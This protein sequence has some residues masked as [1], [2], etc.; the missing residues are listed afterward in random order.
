METSLKL[1]ISSGNNLYVTADISLI[2]AWVTKL[3]IIWDMFNVN[4]WEATLQIC[5]EIKYIAC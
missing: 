4:I 1:S 2:F 3:P 5:N